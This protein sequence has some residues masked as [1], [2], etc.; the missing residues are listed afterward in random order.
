MADLNK[1]Q[2]IGRLTR[3]PESKTTPAGQTVTNFSIATSRVW[4]DKT[5]QKQE[6]TEF[7]NIVSWGKLA[8]ITAKYLKKG[9]KVYVEG[10]LETRDWTPDDGI[11]RYRTEIVIDNMIML[12]SIKQEQAPQV[13]EQQEDQIPF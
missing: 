13:Q 5:G 12:D 11:K 8:E 4:K 6:K 3:D 10:R 9:S 1:S 7:S 2:L